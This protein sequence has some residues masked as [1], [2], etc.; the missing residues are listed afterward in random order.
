M[1][2]SVSSSPACQTLVEA[3]R[4]RASE[5]PDRVAFVFLENGEQESARLTFGELDRLA[6][7]TAARLRASAAAGD[8]ALLLYPQGLDFVVGLFA[9]WYADVVAIPTKAPGASRKNARLDAIAADA[10]AAVALSTTAVRERTAARLDEH[11]PLGRLRWVC[12]DDE[13]DRSASRWTATPAPDRLA[14]LQYTSGST[15]DPK[16]VM[17]NH[18]NLLHNAFEGALGWG[19]DA[20]DAVV[21]WLPTF[22]DL[23]LMIGVLYPVYTGMRSYMMTPA[24]FLAKPL[25]WLEAIARHGGTHSAAPNFAFDLCVDRSTPTQRAA[26]D[27]SGWSMVINGAEPVRASTLH[28]FTEAFAPSGFRATALCPGYGLAEATMRVT[29]SRRGTMPVAVTVHADA[30]MGHRVETAT[31]A[32]PSTT[33]VGCGPTETDT[34]IEIVRPGTV[35]PCDPNEIGEIWISGRSVALG[36]W[37]Q[38]DATQRTFRA[39][40]LDGAGP[41]LRTGDLGFV[42]DGELFVTGRIKDVLIIRGLNHYPQ[43]IEQTVA[44]CH[45]TLRADWGAA[46][47]LSLDGEERVAIVQEVSRTALRTLDAN[48]VI[49]TIRQV[50]A[51]QHDLPVA[52]VLLVRPATIPKTSSG[53]IQRQACRRAL[54][55][56]RL[57]VVA[58]WRQTA[59][60]TDDTAAAPDPS[61]SVREQILTAL[62]SCLRVRSSEIDP[63]QPFARYG[64]DSMSAVLLASTLGDALD[65]PLPPTLVYD[66]PTVDALERFLAGKDAVSSVHAGARATGDPIAVIG[67]GCRFPSASGPDE[68]WALLRDGVDAVCEV[69][70]S[71]WDNEAVHHPEPGTPGRT[72]TR[73]GGFLEDVHGFD[74][75]LFG[76]AP[77]EVT[78]IDP[79]QR[80]LLEVS[81]EALEDAGIAA[82]RLAGT[83]T[84]VFV[85]LSTTDYLTLQLTRGRRATAFTST[86]NAPSVAA[87][88]LS[89]L[90]DL[91]GPAWAV[92]TACSSSL[93][94]VHQ[95][96]RSLRDKECD[97][98]L[99]AGVNLMLTP[100]V[101]VALSQARMLS[102]D[103]R[104]KV[105]DADA[106]GYVRGEGCGVVVLKRLSDA[107]SAGD[108]IVAVIRGTAVNQDG[109]S[110]GLTAPNPAAQEAVV[111]RALVDGG[112]DAAQVDYVEAH[113]TGTVLGDPIELNALKRVLAPGRGADQTL[114]V[115]SIKTN[116][117]HLEAAAGIAGFI[118]VALSLQRRMIPPH[119]HLRQLNPHIADT[120]ATVRVPQ[121]AMAWPTRHDPRIGGVSSFGFGGTNA[122]V[123]LEEATEEPRATVEVERPCHL[124][125]TSARTDTALASLVDRCDRWLDSTDL[126]RGDICFTASTGRSH[127]EHRAASLLMADRRVEIERRALAPDDAGPAVAFLFTGQGAQHAGMGAQLYASEPRFRELLDRCAELADAELQRPLLEVLF[128]KSGS[129]LGRTAY[130]QPALFAVEYALAMLWR[131]WGIEPRAVLGHSIGEYVAATMAGIFTLEEALRLVVERGR[132][133]QALPPGGAMAAL[134]ADPSDVE[135]AL[136]RFE[137]RVSIAAVNGPRSVVISGDTEAV[138]AV[139]ALFTGT[140]LEVSHAF[141]SSRMNPMLT[142]FAEVAQAV[143]YRS[144]QLPIAA[145]LTGILDDGRMSTA[146]YWVRQA[147]EPVRFADAVTALSRTGVDTFVEIGP[148]PVLSRLGR[149]SVT[150]STWLASLV[151]GDGEW[152]RMLGSL[153]RLFVRG[154][155]IDWGRLDPPG[156]RRKVAFPT[157]PFERR[158]FWLETTPVASEADGARDLVQALRWEQ[159]DRASGDEPPT[160]RGGRWLLFCDTEGVAIGV[161]EWLRARGD[162]VR[163]V[164]PSTASQPV[165]ADPLGSDS[166]R[167][168]VDPNRAVDVDRVLSAAAVDGPLAGVICFQGLDL[169]GSSV[170]V[171]ERTLSAAVDGCERLLHVVR[172]MS[173]LAPAAGGQPPRL[174]VVTRGAA[175]VPGDVGGALAQ[176]PLWGFG[177]SV[178]MEQRSLWGGLIDLDP[179]DND[180][181]GELASCWRVAAT[182]D[183]LAARSGRVLAPRLRSAP[184]LVGDPPASPSGDGTYLVTGGTGGLGLLVAGW[185]VDRGARSVVLVSRRGAEADAAVRTVARWQEAGVEVRVEAADVASLDALAGVISRIDAS[186]RPLR[187]IV[188]AAGVLDDG[189]L[190][191]LD[192]AR[193]ETVCRPKIAGALA[194]DQLTGDREL[195]FVIQFSS[196]SALVGA[197]GQANYAAASA[198]LDAFAVGRSRPGR[199]MLAVN[200]GLWDGEGLGA[201]LDVRHRNRLAAQGFT[202]LTAAE[203]VHAFGRLLGRQGSV[204]VARADWAVCGSGRPWSSVLRPFHA[205]LAAGPAG[206]SSGWLAHR[207]R[208]GAA[209]ESGELLRDAV[210]GQVAAVLGCDPDAVP[211][212]RGFFDLGMDSLLAMDLRARLEAALDDTLPPT[213][214]F[215]HPTTARLAAHLAHRFGAGEPVT[216]DTSGPTDPARDTLTE[217]E[218][219]SPVELEA[220]IDREVDSLLK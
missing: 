218:R 83:S 219:L 145:N 114:W 106:D 38:A 197:A 14:M 123:V 61:R 15:S 62:S 93:V 78:E 199:P 10:E 185:L 95:A 37:N 9:C 206:G 102:A 67:L 5:T 8:R 189:I 72:N 117:G 157:Y 104:C 147:R 184:E 198:F 55:E 58:E 115:G 100:D 148:A 97:M 79:Q 27:L 21:S 90:L 167:W 205:G 142:A 32:A 48:D 137:A 172:A 49:A 16:G 202:P 28:R 31:D 3:L 182:E 64:M 53:K 144:A 136:V 152:E 168:R 186:G 101:T 84:G 23:G 105:F 165:A 85:G 112:V 173:G 134:V 66:H 146:D 196:I 195:D 200:W 111:E 163:L 108:R 207:V 170:G 161:A 216:V 220:L 209:T 204:V 47:Q 34:R 6:G 75:V 119:L 1:A 215:D 77:R 56:G 131:S 71:R 153:G 22:H 118:K 174:W 122:H 36:Y 135:S 57:S 129:D 88:R 96:V 92:D 183:Q 181:I 211:L 74:P 11:T 12:S 166:D 33:L 54:L 26:L 91:R 25:R 41:F 217:V 99:A 70:A 126:D 125:V 139:G 60:P 4:T 212:E 82:D 59:G 176:A 128:E 73:R 46:F 208:Q 158:P 159:V 150:G 43:D 140:R 42:R 127:L 171:D 193:V 51:Q 50:V 17:V 203:G 44:A 86:G 2:S 109:R 94:A 18:A 116:I 194:L 169:P 155:P 143:D 81:W 164:V 141:H 68:T 214:T 188:H 190:Q 192:R 35:A 63:R 210:R 175:P 45:P 133:M 107:V 20:A 29:C 130:T 132:L 69:P 191:K 30:L 120:G 177:R 13:T 80:L 178:A 124:L 7:T 160:G 213:L 201:H 180:P 187:G 24:A 65:R 89:Y 19:D 162:E 138:D 103:G 151:P 52:V 121:Q 154:A 87:S 156:T 98:A 40:T 149:Q 179:S 39:R 76:I 110:N 113:G